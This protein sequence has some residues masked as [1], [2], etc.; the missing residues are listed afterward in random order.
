VVGD[1]L[2]N[3]AVD[4]AYWFITGKGDFAR[5]GY[6]LSPGVQAQVGQAVTTIVDGIHEGVF[7]RRPPAIPAYTF[8]DCYYCSPD[9]MS[10]AEARREW[11]RKRL[12]PALARYV[13]L[14]EP[15]VLGDLG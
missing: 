7:P 6:G 13:G 15:E 10:T 14:C 9:G 11:E 8:V 2:G 12:D 1:L 5:I 3:P 4:A